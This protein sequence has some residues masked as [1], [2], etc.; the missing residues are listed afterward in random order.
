MRRKSL[1]RVDRDTLELVVTID[2]PEMYQKPFVALRDLRTRGT[3]L[4]EQLCVPSEAQRYLEI[5]G[6]PAF[7]QQ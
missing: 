7:D 2:D 3:E 4:D 6:K 5:M 1:G